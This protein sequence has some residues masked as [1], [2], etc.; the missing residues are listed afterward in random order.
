LSALQASGQLAEAGRSSTYAVQTKTQ[1]KKTKTATRSIE[2]PYTFGCKTSEYALDAKELSR[3]TID[4]AALSETSLP[5]ELSSGYIFFWKG[6]A[7]KED[8]IHGVVLVIKASLLKQQPDLPTGIH[9]MLM[10]I[11]I[12]L[13]N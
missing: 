7:E 4:I 10:K 6:K 13:R 1:N 11:L 2:R 3:Y 9:G 5:G 8:I 12:P